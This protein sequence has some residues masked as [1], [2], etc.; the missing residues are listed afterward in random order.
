MFDELRGKVSLNETILV[1]GNEKEKREAIGY[2]HQHY[3]RKID[4][5][6]LP[7]YVKGE[8]RVAVANYLEAKRDGKTLL[9]HWEQE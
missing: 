1:W 3:R 7:E 5:S 4:L 2:L 6:G 8:A 9:H